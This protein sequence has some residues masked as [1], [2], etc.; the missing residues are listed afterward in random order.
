MSATLGPEV[1]LEALVGSAGLTLRQRVVV[2]AR[3]QGMETKDISQ[4]LGVSVDAV[5]QLESEA[6]KR[7]RDV[8]QRGAGE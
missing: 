6:I 7:L 5:R 8:A 2:Q 3:R 4:L 1:D